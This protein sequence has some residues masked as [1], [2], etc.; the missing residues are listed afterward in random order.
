MNE[1]VEGWGR[2]FKKSG[3]KV[4]FQAKSS[5][6]DI[7]F[8]LPRDPSRKQPNAEYSCLLHNTEG[9]FRWGGSVH[10][11][12]L[13]FPDVSKSRISVTA[14]YNR[15]PKLHHGFI[16]QKR[17]GDKYYLAGGGDD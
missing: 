12:Y 11:Q 1:R 10:T 13:T 17:G 14:L 2:K 7:K 4:W 15:N 3:A 9:G 6:I 5:Q 16:A 8:N